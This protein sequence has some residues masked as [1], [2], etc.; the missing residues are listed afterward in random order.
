VSLKDPDER[1][2]ALSDPRGFL[3]RFTAGVILDEVQ[4]VRDL[5]SYLHSRPSSCPRL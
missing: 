2:F 4:R 3:A 5:F 1:A